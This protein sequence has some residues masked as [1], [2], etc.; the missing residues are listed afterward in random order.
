MSSILRFSA[1]MCFGALMVAQAH[2][3]LLGYYPIGADSLSL[4]NEDFARLIDAANELLRK[5][6]LPVGAT[7]SWHNAQSGSSGTI[8]VTKTF[9][10]N[11]MLCHTLTYETTPTATP[12]ANR[13]TLNW[14]KTQDGAWKILS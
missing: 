14:C 4:N 11:A 8:R 13:T 9:N 2:S 12:P 10:R 1:V 3:Q 7:T 5:S 6:P